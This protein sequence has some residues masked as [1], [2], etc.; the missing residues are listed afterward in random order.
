[1][2]D[3]AGVLHDP[4]AGLLASFGATLDERPFRADVIA[5]AD[6]LVGLSYQR[7]TLIPAD[8]GWYQYRCGTDSVC[9]ARDY[10]S[11]RWNPWAT[12]TRENVLASSAGWTWRNAARTEADYDI[13]RLE[14]YTSASTDGGRGR[15][16]VDGLTGTLEHMAF[17]VGFERSRFWETD[18]ISDDFRN[19]WTGV[20]G[21]LSASL[22]SISARWSGLIVGYQSNY[23]WGENPFVEGRASVDFSLSTNLVDVKF[24]DVASRDG[25]RKPFRLRFRGSTSFS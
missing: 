4:R 10:D 25:K 20:Q 9:E 24:S 3:V 7:N 13:L 11:N 19:H 5:S 23:D 6:Y 17:G 18:A 12:T 21:A 15:Y 14:R 22:P 16:V 1:M 8:D 2:R